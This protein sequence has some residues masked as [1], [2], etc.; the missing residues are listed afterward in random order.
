MRLCGWVVSVLIL[1]A[2]AADAYM[3]GKFYYKGKTQEKVIALTF[4][5]GPGHFTVPILELLKQHHIK[6]T[7][8]ME[9]SQVETYPEIAKMVF[10][11]GHEIGNHT[12]IHFDYHKAKNAAPERLAH[13]LAQTESALKRAVGIQTNVVRMPYGY[14]NKSWLLPTLKEHGYALVHWSFGEDWMA[15]RWKDPL[16][17]TT[18]LILTPDVMADDYIKNAQPGAVFLFHDGGR[19]RERTLAAVT[20]VIDA[21]EKKGYR[22]I[23]AKEMFPDAQ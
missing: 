14:F 21:L 20:T 1:N 9:G 10:D 2:A 13:E 7:F 6:A 18:K 4:D 19:H 8:F 12:Y 11:A 3:P 16:T 23:P 22:F 17:K 5:D 15:Y